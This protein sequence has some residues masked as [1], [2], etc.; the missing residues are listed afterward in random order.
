MMRMNPR[1]TIPELAE[2]LGR[3]ARAIEMQVAKLKADGLIERVGPA[4]GGHW[5]VRDDT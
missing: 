4:K 3:T 5:L 1:V 2:A